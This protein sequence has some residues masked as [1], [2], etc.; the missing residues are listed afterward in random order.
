[1]GQD[2]EYSTALSDAELLT[3]AKGE[4]RVLLTRDLAL[5]QRAAAK[6]IQAYYVEG[7]TEPERLA[8]ISAHFSISLTI[9]LTQSRCPKC[10]GKLV[11]IP[12]QEI[13]D[14]VGKNTLVCYNDFWACSK[15]GAVY[16]Q[17]AHWTKIRATLEEAKQKLDVKKEI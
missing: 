8:E 15:C 6:G 4:N 3:I 9:D 2:A 16:W 13:I 10:N 17:G 11:S 5:Y 14:K 1:M 12:K 7:K